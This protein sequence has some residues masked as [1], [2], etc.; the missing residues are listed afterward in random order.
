[1]S[2][3]FTMGP[4]MVDHTRIVTAV[5]VYGKGEMHI[6][7]VRGWGFLTGRGSGA[8]AMAEGLAIVIQ[9]AN[10]RLI[11]AAPAMY[12]MLARFRDEPQKADGGYEIA[13]ELRDLLAGIE[14]RP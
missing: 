6:A 14:G 11:A 5:P 12:T 13:M 10:A 7:D 4:W 8:L 2:A 3:K 1:V 9:D